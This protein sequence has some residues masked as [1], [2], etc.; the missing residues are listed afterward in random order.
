MHGAWQCVGVD[1]SKDI[2]HG[3]FWDDHGWDLCTRSV[4]CVHDLDPPTLR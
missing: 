3:R 4:H 2:G 1:A